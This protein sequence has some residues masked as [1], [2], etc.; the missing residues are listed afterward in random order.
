MKT[1]YKELKISRE[2]A[3]RWY[4]G[5]DKEL[6]GLALTAFPDLEQ[7]KCDFKEGELLALSYYEDFR[8]FSVKKFKE[9]RK[10]KIKVDEFGYEWEFAKRIE[11]T[12]L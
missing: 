6:K 11:Y 1:E 10:D 7:I 8:F 12:L 5:E 9:Y 2:T 4:N 3:E